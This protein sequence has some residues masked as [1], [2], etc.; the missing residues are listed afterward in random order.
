MEVKPVEVVEEEPPPNDK[1]VNLDEMTNAELVEHMA[2]KVLPR[3]LK[4]ILAPV[5]ARLAEVGGFIKGQEDATVNT[6]VAAARLK[7]E[8]FNDLK[9]DIS[10][11]FKENPGLNVEECYVIAKG[12]AV[13]GGPPKKKV[14]TEKPTATGVKPVMTKKELVRGR[15]GFDAILREAMEETSS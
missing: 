4:K 10:K 8:D 15:T 7:H 1:K 6:Q 11:V 9:N 12:R 5:E 14:S 3:A 13:A 2:S